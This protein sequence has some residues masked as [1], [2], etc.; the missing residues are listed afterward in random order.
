ML[1]AIDKVIST[2]RVNA[3]MSAKAADELAEEPVEPE[4]E[5]DDEDGAD[6]ATAQANNS[7]DTEDESRTAATPSC[8]AATKTFGYRWVSTRSG[9]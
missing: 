1:S 8:W 9:S 5:P 4:V 7:D 6:S 3:A 2:P